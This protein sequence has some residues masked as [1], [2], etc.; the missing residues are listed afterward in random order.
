[1]MAICPSAFYVAPARQ[2]RLPHAC[3]ARAQGKS[4]PTRPH[5]R[6]LIV[7]GERQQLVCDESLCPAPWPSRLVSQLADP[8]VQPGAS[9]PLSPVASPGAPAT[10]KIPTA[11]VLCQQP[12]PPELKKLGCVQ[13]RGPSVA[14]PGLLSESPSG[15]FTQTH[16][17]PCTFP[18]NRP[19]VTVA[20]ALSTSPHTRWY[21]SLMAVTLGLSPVPLL[22]L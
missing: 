9:V 10:P 13:L 17:R 3:Y 22:P 20:L 5:T 16:I 14:S 12:R 1:M 7:D 19:L 15:S 6:G 18:P 2:S 4:A 8:K 11:L 21:L